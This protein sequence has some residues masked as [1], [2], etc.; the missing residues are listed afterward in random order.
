VECGS[1]DGIGPMFEYLIPIGGTIKEEFL[2]EMTSQQVGF[3][4][5]KDSYHS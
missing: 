2:E 1:L 3:E 4:V 5:S